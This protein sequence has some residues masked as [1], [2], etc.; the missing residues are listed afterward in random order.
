[1]TRTPHLAFVILF[2]LALNGCSAAHKNFRSGQESEEKGLFEEAMYRYAEAVKQAPDEPEYRLKF[3]NARHTAA[4]AREIRGDSL[5]S[6]KRFA[7][8]AHEFQLASGLDPSQPR[9]LQKAQQ[10]RQ[11]M[12][13]ASA[14]QEGLEFEKNNKLREAATAFKHAME[15]VADNPDYRAAALRIAALRKSKLEGFELQLKSKQPIT[16]RFKEAKLKDIF[17]VISQLSGIN[18]VF[19]NDIKDQNVTISLEKATFYQAVDLI[20]S[21]Y[22]LAHKPLNENTVLVY[23]LSSDKIKQY[24]ELQLRTFYLNHLDAKKAANLVRSMLQVKRLYINE[25]ANALVVRDTKEVTDVI[26]RMLEAQDIPEAEVVLDV[27]VIELSDKDTHSL[28]LLL[29]NYNVQLG[30]FSPSG[31]LLATTLKDTTA[32]SATTTTTTATIDNL[33]RAFSINRFGGYVTVPNAQYNFGKTLANGEVLSNPKIRVKNKEKAKFNVGTRVPITTTTMATTGSTSQVN[34][35]YVDVGVKVNAE[36]TIQ[37][38]NEVSIKLSLEVS[39]ILSR[40]TVGGKDS[41]TTV[42]T[43]GTRNLDTVLSL[44]DGET[45]VIGGLISRNKSD[46][47]QKVFLLGDIPLLGPLLSS[48]EASNDKTELILAITPRL[49]RGVTVQP[50]QISSFDSGKE[51]TPSL[52][53]PYGA[54][55]EEAEYAALPALPLA[56]TPVPA[57]PQVPT[58]LPQQ[59]KTDVL[60]PAASQPAL[61]PDSAPQASE[62]PPAVAPPVPSLDTRTNAPPVP[63][64]PDSP[65]RPSAPPDREKP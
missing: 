35:Q 30:A 23:P 29:S 60:Q 15:L 1:M 37:V 53:P 9:Y 47:K 10:T 26:A 33:V 5:L 4:K 34:V 11:L 14:Y 6:E 19:D 40:E 36:P 54:F 46:S 39:S 21:M 42:V 58:P 63:E 3:L 7:E 28:G 25:D 50:A 45:S 17:A 20:A 48:S 51:D 59:E 22:K 62:Q 18:F 65:S 13:A 2:C 64:Q 16:L 32:T 44:K 24:Q 61:P 52:I 55:E 8:A 57:P 38:N 41:A 49:V 27:E 31:N 12:E 56:A 43:I